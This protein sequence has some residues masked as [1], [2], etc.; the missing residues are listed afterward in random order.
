MDRR[1]TQKIKVAIALVYYRRHKRL[2]EDQELG[3]IG[4]CPEKS[5]FG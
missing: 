3:V 5:F 1:E 4:L 2:G